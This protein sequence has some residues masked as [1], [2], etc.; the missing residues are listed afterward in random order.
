M[1]L[2]HLPSLWCRWRCAN[3]GGAHSGV[4]T[5][6]RFS[7]VCCAAVERAVSW[8]RRWCAMRTYVALSVAAVLALASCSSGSE[9]LG[10]DTGSHTSASL[11]PAR[12]V[13]IN[14]SARDA[15][16][17]GG[18]VLGAGLAGTL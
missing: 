12:G 18:M 10:P 11:A 4:S 5:R 2:T 16:R 9:S 7:I 13:H 8:A 3:F 15:T 1:R 17:D 6:T 14:L